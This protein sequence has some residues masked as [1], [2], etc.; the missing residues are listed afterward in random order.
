M[1]V[2]G[3]KKAREIIRRAAFYRGEVPE[4]HP[5]FPE[6]S[7]AGCQK[8]EDRLPAGEVANLEYSA[9]DDAAIEQFLRERVNTTW[10][11]LGTCKMVP[12]ERA[13]GHEHGERERY[14]VVD[15]TLAVYGVRGLR[16]ADLSVIPENIGSNTNNTAML[17]GEMAAKF[18]A[19]DVL[20]LELEGA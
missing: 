10:H 6:G 11:S 2:W 7:K 12:R 17:V 18:V 5:R 1:L 13:E 15:E 20:G 8:F 19:R 9:E 16:L 3:Y 4:T 14:G